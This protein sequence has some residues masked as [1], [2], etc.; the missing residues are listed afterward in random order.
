MRSRFLKNNS[1]FSLIELI[2][3]V[4][5]MGIM[6]GGA[7]I[8][9]STI[10]SA[11]VSSASSMTMNLLKQGRQK[12]MGMVNKTHEVTES[13]VT[14]V[15]TTDI[16][17]EFYIVD[18]SLYGSVKQMVSGVA[19]DLLTEKLCS[20]RV[21]ITFVQDSTPNKWKLGSTY[22][23]VKIYFKKGNGSIASIKATGPLGDEKILADTIVI[24]KPDSTDTN[25]TRT[26]ILV[27]GTGRAYEDR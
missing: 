12:A 15:D 3:V 25:D 20:D 24:D 1:G 22:S 27:E 14:K 23:K 2:V 16:F 19:E 6:S 4:L 11:R 21:D 9:M 10:M 17:V 5:I 18:K 7:I 13:G 8:A 26:I